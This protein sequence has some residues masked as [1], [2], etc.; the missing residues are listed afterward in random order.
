M[1][2]RYAALISGTQETFRHIRKLR[3]RIAQKN[4]NDFWP[5]T[6]VTPSSRSHF[7]GDVT[8]AFH[9]STRR[10]KKSVSG[11][12]RTSFGCSSSRGPHFWTL[13]AVYSG[14]NSDGPVRITSMFFFNRGAALELKVS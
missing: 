14:P 10:T 5:M 4:C 13:P 1:S 8:I 3:K 11:L 6:A 12:N 2:G 7:F 9:T